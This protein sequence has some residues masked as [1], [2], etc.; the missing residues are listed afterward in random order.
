MSKMKKGFVW[1]VLLIASNLAQAGIYTEFRIKTVEGLTGTMKV[2]YQDG[3]TRSQVVMDTKEVTLEGMENMVMLHLKEQADKNFIIEKKIIL[4]EASKIYYEGFQNKR[5]NEYKAEEEYRNYHI[6]ILGKEMVNGYHCTHVEVSTTLKGSSFRGMEWWVSEEVFGYKE[7]Q[8]IKIHQFNSSA[9]FK[10]MSEIRLEGFSVKM[11]IPGE[12]GKMEM[13]LMK[14]E[15]MDIP[16]SMFSIDGYT[17]KERMPFGPGEFDNEKIKDKSIE[18][19]VKYYEEM[20]KQ[21]GV[22]EGKKD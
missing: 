6:T 8:G 11:L 10:A 12:I 22:P 13:E 15:K 17:K 18:E 5:R 14:A 7:M 20:Q 16:G 9:I 19:L 21:M 4:D 3:N 1:L 2:W